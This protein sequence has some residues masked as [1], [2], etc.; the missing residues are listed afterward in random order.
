MLA[1]KLVRR[2]LLVAILVC[3]MLLP[4]AVVMADSHMPPVP[5]V[6][7]RV[8]PAPIPIMPPSSTAVRVEKVGGFTAVRALPQG[9]VYGYVTQNLPVQSA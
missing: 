7:P 2:S 4:T 1:N 8:E 5:I 9:V 3:A 6:G